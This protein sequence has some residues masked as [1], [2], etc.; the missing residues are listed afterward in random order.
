MIRPAFTA[1]SSGVGVT[2][3]AGGQAATRIADGYPRI[4][5]VSVH[6]HGVIEL[7]GWAEPGGQWRRVI[8]SGGPG[9]IAVGL[10][11]PCV[12]TLGPRERVVAVDRVFP[13]LRRGFRERSGPGDRRR[14]GVDER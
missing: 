14:S 8:G 3:D 9:D 10:P 13:W 6:N 5:R 11:G 2:G 7:P 1:Y 4:S 12:G